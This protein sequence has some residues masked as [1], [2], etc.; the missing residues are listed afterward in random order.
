MKDLHPNTSIVGN[1]WVAL[2]Y[3]FNGAPGVGYLCTD[4][5]NICA[6]IN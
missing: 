5:L 3:A 2:V 1:L 4:L 6:I